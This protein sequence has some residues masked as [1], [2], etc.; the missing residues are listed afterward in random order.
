MYILPFEVF[1]AFSPS[2]G[3]RLHQQAAPCLRTQRHSPAS[4]KRSGLTMHGHRT[5]SLSRRQGA[6]SKL[7]RLRAFSLCPYARTG[8][9][10]AAESMHPE[11]HTEPAGPKTAFQTGAA[12]PGCV[13]ECCSQP[14]PKQLL[15]A[16]GCSRAERSAQP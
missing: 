14:R 3:L 8:R 11:Q 9:E 4:G 13:R 1:L 7:E 16:T 5:R 2:R 10:R 15:Q 6:G 12:V